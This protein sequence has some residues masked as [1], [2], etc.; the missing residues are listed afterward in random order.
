[1]C[2]M[3]YPPVVFLDGVYDCN[4]LEQIFSVAE[5]FETR[6]YIISTLNSGGGT[7]GSALHQL[8]FHHNIR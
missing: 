2:S 5:I 6:P 3:P 7:R 8:M 1:M 4:V